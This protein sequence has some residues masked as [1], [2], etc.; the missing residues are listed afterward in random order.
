VRTEYEALT[1]TRAHRP[2]AIA[3]AAARRAR[4][5]W[6]DHDREMLVIAA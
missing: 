1:R 2:Q 6:P 4:R 3:E 5:P